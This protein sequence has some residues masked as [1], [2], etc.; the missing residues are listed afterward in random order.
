MSNVNECLKKVRNSKREENEY[1]AQNPECIY[2]P[3]IE[4]LLCSSVKDFRK[5]RKYL[6]SDIFP[7]LSEFCKTRRSYFKVMDIHQTLIEGYHHAYTK[8]HQLKITLDYITKHSPFLLCLLGETYGDYCTT[9]FSAEESDIQGLTELER[10]IYTAAKNGYSWIL[11]EPHITCS[12]ME[13]EITEAAFLNDSRSSFFYYRDPQ[14]IDDILLNVPQNERQTI[15]HIYKSR[16]HEEERKI[17]ELKEK[18]VS[19]GL[20]VTFFRTLEELG[21]AVLKD[22]RNIIDNLYPMDSVP[23]ST[24]HE[25]YLELSYH[26]AFAQKYC[27][28]FVENAETQRVFEI[29]D[30]F[31]A[32]PQSDESQNDDQIED[33]SKITDLKQS[34]HSSIVEPRPNITFDCKSLL[35]LSGDT[36]CGKTAMICNWLKYFRKK[37]PNVLVVSQYVGCSYAS[38]DIMSF[39]RRCILR[40]RLEYFGAEDQPSTFS[41]NSTDTWIF[42]VLCEAFRAAIGLKPCVLVI[43]GADRLSETRGLSAQQVKEFSWLPQCLPAQCRLIV[44][45]VSSNKAYVSLSKHQDVK[46]VHISSALNYE[47][48]AKIFQAHRTGH[49]E[50]I[51]Q[52]QIQNIM[53]RKLSCLPLVLVILANELQISGP[54]RNNADYLEEYLDCQTIPELW[55]A[56]LKRWI[57][58]YSWIKDKGASDCSSSGT[59]GW[60]VDVLCLLSISRCGLT[61]VDIHQLLAYLGYNGADKVNKYDWTLFRAAS[62]EWI[63]EMPDGLLNFTH[64]SVHDAVG[65]FL[66]GAIVPLKESTLKSPFTCKRSRIHHLFQEYLSRQTYTLKLYQELPWQLRTS[67]DLSDLCT[68]LSNPLIMY[69]IYRN[70]KHSYQLK[71]DLVCYWDVL[72]KAGFDSAVSYQNMVNELVA[73]SKLSAKLRCKSRFT[74]DDSRVVKYNNCVQAAMICFTAEFLKE[75][76]KSTA[77]EQLLLIAQSLLPMSCPLNLVETEIHFKVHY[78]IGEMSLTAGN[79]QNAEKHFQRALHSIDYAPKKLRKCLP[80]IIICTVQLLCKLAN[81]MMHEGSPKVNEIVQKTK[82]MTQKIHNPYGEANLKI[83]EGFQNIHVG[84][85]SVAEQ[86]FRD[87]LD[88]RQKWYGEFHPLVGELMEHLGDILSSYEI[89]K[90]SQAVGIYR[91]VIKIQEETVRQATSP[92][93]REQIDLNKALTISKLGKLLQNE[94]GYRV[95][96]EAAECLRQS[97]DLLTTLLGS[98]HHLTM[99]V[100]RSLKQAELQIH[101]DFV[102]FKR[103]VIP[104]SEK[105]LSLPSTKENTLASPRLT[106]KKLQTIKSGLRTVA[107]LKPAKTIGE[108][109]TDVCPAIRPG[110]KCEDDDTILEQDDL[111]ISSS[112]SN[113]HICKRDFPQRPCPLMVQQGSK[114]PVIK[115]NSTALAKIHTQAAPVFK[116]SAPIKQ[117]TFAHGINSLTPPS[118]IIVPSGRLCL[119]SFILAASNSS[120]PLLPK[121]RTIRRN[122]EMA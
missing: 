92:E 30:T 63:Q 94:V 18:I 50:G 115:R 48:Q 1:L 52:S 57:E 20:P 75:L 74:D 32:F 117:A 104:T 28:V 43:D 98:N 5:E 62:M 58:D 116:R 19:K 37:N 122:T 85:F 69:T 91:Q 25:S 76:Q 42:Q 26:E 95:K 9:C 100:R 80:D 112:A 11:N 81:L 65:Y 38:Y 23:L 16:N 101:K 67:G 21:E 89:S 68:F 45:T 47:E 113:L 51:S 12:L 111:A 87:A 6:Q 29:L 34:S 121:R 79:L 88:I 108:T 96:R 106:S 59:T 105:S 55:N 36:G 119:A 90:R 46:V 22:C 78:C 73:T 31:A 66:L 114:Y 13:L 97:F 60:V 15:Y 44:T 4:V 77:A 10:N 107:S 64:Y 40:L 72:S 93:S 99:D 103:P 82:K 41:E 54:F 14:H 118:R 3:P 8:S 61:E 110:V 39:M 53:S 102:F 71:M 7:I 33:N 17:W 56:V 84:I 24:D 83:L 2:R 35:L 49:L 120:R 109:Q 27:K 86:C 70:A